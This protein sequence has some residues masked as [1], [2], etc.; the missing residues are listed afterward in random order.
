MMLQTEIAVTVASLADSWNWGNMRPAMIK[1]D[2]IA[3]PVATRFRR[4]GRIGVL[5]AAVSLGLMSACGRSSG[6][7]QG[8]THNAADKHPLVWDAGSWDDTTWN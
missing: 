2:P 8:Q 3:R 7:I 5:V 1:H 4:G 6:P